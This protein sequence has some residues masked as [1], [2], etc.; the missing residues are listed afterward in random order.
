MFEV[1]P[2]GLFDSMFAAVCDRTKGQKKVF[3]IFSTNELVLLSIYWR[4][5][6][7]Q[8]EIIDETYLLTSDFFYY[9]DRFFNHF[10]LEVN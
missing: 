7:F 8:F 1:S 4:F 3:V 6:C 5:S 2:G 9:L 10:A